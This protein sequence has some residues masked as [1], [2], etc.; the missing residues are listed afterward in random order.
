MNYVFVVSPLSLKPL[1][2][3]PCKDW[4]ARSMIMQDEWINPYL[5]ADRCFS[6]SELA[7]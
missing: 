5:Q 7:L 3:K 6:T 2:A 4:L 1:V